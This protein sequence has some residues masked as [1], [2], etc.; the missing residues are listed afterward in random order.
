M[1]GRDGLIAVREG[2]GSRFVASPLVCS[3]TNNELRPSFF[4]AF[5]FLPV[6]SRSQYCR[7]FFVVGRFSWERD[8][9]KGRREEEWK[10]SEIEGEEVSVFTYFLGFRPPQISE[11]EKRNVLQKNR[12]SKSSIPSNLWQGEQRASVAINR[13]D[14]FYHY[15]L[16]RRSKG[17]LAPPPPPAFHPQQPSPSVPSSP[18]SLPP[19]ASPNSSPNPTT[20]PSSPT[21]ASPQSRLPRARVLLLG[22]RVRGGCRSRWKGGGR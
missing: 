11:R 8:E 7:S 18:S 21:R 15:P 13:F 6:H 12:A 22:R 14:L 4:S 19:A 3:T 9:S 10:K 1:R 20:S 16:P 17:K 5:A 2:G